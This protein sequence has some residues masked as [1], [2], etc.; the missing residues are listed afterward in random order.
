MPEM[1][2]HALKKATIEN[3]PKESPEKGK[4]YTGVGPMNSMNNY[5]KQI[6][7]RYIEVHDVYVTLDFLCSNNAKVM[8]HFLT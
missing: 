5:I 2:P 8:I 3:S 1:S 7:Q 6:C 4:I